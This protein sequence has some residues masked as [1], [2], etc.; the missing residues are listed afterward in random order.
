[1]GLAQFTNLLPQ[2]CANHTSYSWNQSGEYNTLVN[3]DGNATPIRNHGRTGFSK[4]W[5]LPASVLSLPLP[6]PARLFFALTPIYTQ[7]ESRKAFY[8]RT[9][10]TQAIY[11]CEQPVNK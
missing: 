3:E 4:S 7:P 5:G 9:V 1:M 11:S 2:Q 6:P 10:S 8:T